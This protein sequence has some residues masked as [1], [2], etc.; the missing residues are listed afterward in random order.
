MKRTPSFK[1]YQY[2]KDTKMYR[3]RKLLSYRL[4]QAMVSDKLSRTICTTVRLLVIGVSQ[5]SLMVG[6]FPSKA[7]L[8]HYEREKLNPQRSAAVE[9]SRH[10]AR[11]QASTL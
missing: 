4:H 3:L 2:L 6:G 7:L 5:T 9:V 11:L 10:D 1:D 8:L